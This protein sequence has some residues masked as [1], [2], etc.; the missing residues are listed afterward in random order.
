MAR[1]FTPITKKAH[2]SQNKA[3]SPMSENKAETVPK[4]KSNTKK[5]AKDSEEDM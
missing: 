4:K 5:S 3:V 2:P 1:V